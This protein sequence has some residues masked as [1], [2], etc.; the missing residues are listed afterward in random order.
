MR[1]AGFTEEIKGT[2]VVSLIEKWL[3]SILGLSNTSEIER[4]HHTIQSRLQEGRSL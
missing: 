3:P 2:D 1:I 4:A